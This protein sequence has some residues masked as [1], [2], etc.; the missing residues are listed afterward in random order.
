MAIQPFACAI[1]EGGQ[2]DFLGQPERECYTDCFY[3]PSLAH[4]CP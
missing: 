4:V 1:I 3:T 2:V